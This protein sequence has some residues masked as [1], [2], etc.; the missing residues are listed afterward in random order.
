MYNYVANVAVRS[1]YL[2]VERTV[3]CPDSWK[4]VS[5]AE[6]KYFN[7]SVEG[8]GNHPIIFPSIHGRKLQALRSVERHDCLCQLMKYIMMMMT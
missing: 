7:V 5:V 2:Q 4:L 3:I 8:K 6:L 1:E